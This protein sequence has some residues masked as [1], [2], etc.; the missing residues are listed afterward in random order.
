MKVTQLLLPSPKGNVSVILFGFTI[1][2]KQKEVA[3]SS[4]HYSFF[5]FIA[6]I[7]PVTQPDVQ[8]NYYM[9]ILISNNIPYLADYP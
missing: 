5:L 9:D 2:K 3:K 8:T 7:F 6:V 1:V 4:L